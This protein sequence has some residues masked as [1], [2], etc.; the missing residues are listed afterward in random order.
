MGGTMVA[1]QA[2]KITEK[3]TSSNEG[4]TSLVSILRRLSAPLA[5]AYASTLHADEKVTAP[6]PP[7][8]AGIPADISTDKQAEAAQAEWKGWRQKFRGQIPTESVGADQLA[9]K[10]RDLRFRVSEAATVQLPLAF[11]INETSDK[12]LSVS[13]ARLAPLVRH[14]H[15]SREGILKL[16]MAAHQAILDIERLEKR[17]SD[18]ESRKESMVPIMENYERMGRRIH[19]EHEIIREHTEIQ[20]K[21]DPTLAELRELEALHAAKASGSPHDAARFKQLSRRIGL[22]SAGEVTEARTDLERIRAQH[23][24]P[25]AKAQEVITRL[26]GERNEIAEAAFHQVCEN[27]ESIEGIARKTS[28]LAELRSKLVQD[29][30]AIRNKMLNDVVKPDE[31]EALQ[32]ELALVETDLKRREY[33]TLSARGNTSTTFVFDTDRSNSPMLFIATNEPA[34]TI[35]ATERGENLHLTLDQP[36]PLLHRAINPEKTVRNY[37]NKNEELVFDEKGSINELEPL[38]DVTGP[39]ISLNLCPGSRFD[40]TSV[41]SSRR[42]FICEGSGTIV[43]GSRGRTP[44]NGITPRIEITTNRGPEP[45]VIS[46]PKDHALTEKDIDYGSFG[47]NLSLQADVSIA[48]KTSPFGALN[49][50]PGADVDIEVRGAKGNVLIPLV[51]DGKPVFD[52]V[53]K[54]FERISAV[55]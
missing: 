43:L 45:L 18:L 38:N 30:S 12:T 21:L 48:T 17:A 6:E 1:H 51:R 22:R 7:S 41:R 15:L 44:T 37:L 14:S 5:M 33:S 26:T 24:A 28:E 36:T 3:P 42:S 10:V 25:I 31:R 11:L 29:T 34:T 47:I 23:D 27:Y 49:E 50:K 53:R 2:A 54:V 9:E 4:L 32:Y 19:F 16:A 20:T 55:E 39:R 46:I 35:T 13:E 8:I 52:E 40:L